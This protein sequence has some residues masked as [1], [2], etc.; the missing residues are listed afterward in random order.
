MAIRR[1][2]LVVARPGPL[3]DGLAALLWSIPL[4]SAV[5]LADGLPSALHLVARHQPTL[6]LVDAELPGGEAWALVRQVKARWPQIRCVAL[7]DTTRSTQQ[8]EDAGANQVLIK[9][10]PAAKLS[11]VLERLL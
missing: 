6:V 1:S 8:A 10:Y 2:A 7:T 3:R 5:H 11:T 4:L 9:G